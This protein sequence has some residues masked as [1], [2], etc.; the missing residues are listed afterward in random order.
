MKTF[1]QTLDL[2]TR[3]NLIKHS[4]VHKKDLGWVFVASSIM[5]LL[6][7]TPM[8]YMLQ[9]FD[10]IFI[11]KSV[12]T[13][14]TVSGI[15]IFFYAISAV[16]GYVRS[17]IIIALGA[18]IEKRVNEKLFNISFKERLRGDVKNPVSYLDDLTI[19]RQWLTGAAV[20]ALFDLP[21]VPLYVSI[22]F[23]MHLTLGYV[24][25]ILIL[26]LILFGVYF[27]KV[28]GNQDEL[29][30]E[31]EYDTND[32][33]YG[34][35]RNSEV[36]AVYSIAANFKQIWKRNKKSFYISLNKSQKKTGAILNIMKQYRFFAN[37]LALTVGAYL[38]ISGE[39]TLGSMIAASLLMARTT[40][41]VDS[42]VAT[43]SRATIVKEAFWR[44]E[45]MLD[46]STNEKTSS[47]EEKEDLGGD[48]KNKTIA[49]IS[50]VNIN[51]SYGENHPKILDNVNLEF[52]AGQVITI[53]GKSGVGKTTFIK[54]LAGLV[55]YKGEIKFDNLPLSA[56]TNANSY[57]LIGYLPQ[58][59]LMLPG[60]IAE[61]IS[62]FRKPDSKRIIEVAKLVGIHDFILTAP[63]GYDSLLLGG[64]QNLSGGERQRIGLARA[65][66]NN[67]ACLFL[68]EPNSALDHSGEKALK[69]VITHCKNKGKIIV[70]VSHRRSVL[71]YSDKII[72]FSDSTNLKVVGQ[73]EFI[74]SIGSREKF[75]KRF[76]F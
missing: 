2:Y 17:K 63:N 58:D 65:I 10:R 30:R 76:N 11:S 64:Y 68:D 41:P 42:A 8:L 47:T 24:A 22:M 12:F 14:L 48:F 13:L 50:L 4:L 62:N 72:D 7:L 9:I 32:F 54:L 35:L 20:F 27:A 6:M 3:S 18:R 39:L 5:N 34:K 55:R 38:V 61:N 36:L 59:V 31:E 66:Y 56:F 51:V 74:N 69:N 67:P 45:K 71:E 70:V 49:K 15:I 16:S 46:M 52:H 29:L 19:V 60:S 1:F 33:L 57:N 23:V 53:V 44:V 75:D 26:I 21:W 25:L 73:K 43:L 28:L 40:M 37:S